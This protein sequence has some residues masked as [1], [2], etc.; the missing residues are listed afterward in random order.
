MEPNEHNAGRWWK[1]CDHCAGRVATMAVAQ[2]STIAPAND[3]DIVMRFR[4]LFAETWPLL[5]GEHF[6]DDTARKSTV[7]TM[8]LRAT[9][10]ELIAHIGPNAKKLTFVFGEEIGRAIADHMAAR[11]T[12][13]N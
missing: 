10:E 7:V 3:E 6:K 13:T 4:A 12:L 5:P 11:N 8:M 2:D 9:V 1:F